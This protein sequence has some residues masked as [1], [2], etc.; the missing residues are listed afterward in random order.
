M[1]LKQCPFATTVESD[2]ETP[3]KKSQQTKAWSLQASVTINAL[4]AE[5]NNLKKKL[6]DLQGALE[7][8]EQALVSFRGYLSTPK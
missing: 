4:K 3:A 8:S 2:Y 7:K 1:H 6:E 5:N